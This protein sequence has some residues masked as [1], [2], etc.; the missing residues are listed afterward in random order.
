MHQSATPSTQSRRGFTLME[1]LVA[2]AITTLI[3]GTILGLTFQL[4]SVYANLNGNARI[5]TEAS[6]IINQLRDDFRWGT[7]DTITEG[8]LTINIIKPSPAAEQI[9]YKFENLQLSRRN[10]TLGEPF[11]LL[12]TSV[13]SVNN[14]TIQRTIQD[15]PSV[16]K[17][18]FELETQGANHSKSFEIYLSE[19]NF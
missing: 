1:V 11:T 15:R 6:N 19:K 13:T 10:V 17:I 16:Y 3:A 18:N 12:H 8:P 4:F 2:L 5:Q 9:T 14:F 7:I